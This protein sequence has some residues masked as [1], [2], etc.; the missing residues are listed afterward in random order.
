MS[1]SQRQSFHFATQHQ[2][3]QSSPPP[4]PQSHFQ[5]QFHNQQTTPLTPPASNTKQSTYAHRYTTQTA[6]PLSSI[7]RTTGTSPAARAQRRNLF[8]NKIKED[9]DAGRFEARGEQLVLMEDVKE[10]RQWRESMGRRAERIMRGFGIDGD[11][12]GEGDLGLTED[13]T[14]QLDEFLSQEQEMEMADMELLHSLEQEQQQQQQ[15]RQWQQNGETNSFSDEEYD[16]I[17]MD[18]PDPALQDQGMDMS[19]G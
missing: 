7:R 2:Q 6:N 11:V 15:Q 4:T 17:F 14:V 10:E 19:S 18:L 5:F 8:L 16:D 9:R 3:Q 1:S 13:E 12:D